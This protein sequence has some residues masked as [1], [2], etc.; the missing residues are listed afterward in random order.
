M[1]FVIIGTD[2]KGA[3]EARKK[4]RA[5]HLAYWGRQGER[6]L[7]AGPFLDEDE[8][9]CGSMMIVEAGDLA[10]ARQMAD[11]DPYVV[12][13]VFESCEVKRWNWLLGKPGAD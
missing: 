3:L 10:E 8:N 13:G 6:F 4:A 5:D 1:Q 11:M 7:A 12:S 2:R 9:P